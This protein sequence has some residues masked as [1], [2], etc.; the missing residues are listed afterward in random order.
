M[1][2][3]GNA[4]VWAEEPGDL[5]GLWKQRLRWAR[6]NVQ[7]S[8]QFSHMW[9]HGRRYGRLG[10][11]AVRPDLVHRRADAGLHGGGVERAAR[12]LRAGRPAGMGAFRFLWI[13][14]AV[15]YV[16][17]TAM[18]CA[19]DPSTARRA[20][21]QGI[22]F[23]GAISLAIIVYS[24]APGADRRGA[25]RRP[26]ARRDRGDR[27]RLDGAV[28]LF[29]YAWL[30]AAMLVAYAAS[31]GWRAAG[32]SRCCR[33]CSFR[34][35]ATARFSAPSRWPPTSARSRGRDSPGTRR[36][37]PERWRC[38]DERALPSWDRGF[39][40]T[41]RRR[42]SRARPA[43]QGAAHR[44]AHRAAGRAAGGAAGE[45]SRSAGD[46]QPARR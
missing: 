41:S 7:I 37:R 2:F 22:L 30:A 33:S 28:Q 21:L 8:L 38:R 46:R 14:H 43:R 4:I 16:F 11:A 32:G 35:P 17:V 12:P 23:P 25:D 9:L 39:T 15:V 13:F 26:R 36:S 20:W 6:G 31:A 42:R 44:R 40:R 3:E 34:S 24:V 19:L 45:R 1:V 5:V 18:S 10:R 29:V 27:A